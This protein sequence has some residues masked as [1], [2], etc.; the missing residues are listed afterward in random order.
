MESTPATAFARALI[1]AGALV[2]RGGAALAWLNLLMVAGTLAGVVLRYLFSI[3]LPALQESVMY[4]HALVFMLGM[5]FTM[6]ADEHV[7][8]DIVYHRLSRRQQ[9]MVN[10]FGALLLLLPFLAFIGWESL[11]YVALSWRSM[12]T[13]QEAGGL[14]WVYLLKSLIPAMVVAMILQAI[15]DVGRN[16]HYLRCNA[17]PEDLLAQPATEVNG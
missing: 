10:V 16:I 9:C 3:S 4:T 12:E 8:V 1:G 7:R 13:S 15:I 14:G 11:D 17:F 6:Q 5:A 2:R